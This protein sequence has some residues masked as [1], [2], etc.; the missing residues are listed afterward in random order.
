MR[1]SMRSSVPPSKSVTAP[2]N[3]AQ[4]N[5]NQQL[6]VNN[7]NLPPS[8]SSAPKNRPTI[9]SQIQNLQNMLVTNAQLIQPTYVPSPSCV[10]PPTS[11]LQTQTQSR[12]SKKEQQIILTAALNEAGETIYVATPMSSDDFHHATDDILTEMTESDFV[13]IGGYDIESD[14][15]IEDS[16]ETAI[17][18]QLDPNMVYFNEMLRLQSAMAHKISELAA[19]VKIIK[20]ATS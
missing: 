3:Q 20:K 2:S 8:E 7:N 12:P 15:I 4:I 18:I 16:D 5:N 19:D 9:S 1:H 6:V 13:P 11:L 17:Q 14:G 10:A